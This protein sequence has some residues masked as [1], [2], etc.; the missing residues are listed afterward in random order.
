MFTHFTIL[1]NNEHEILQSHMSDLNPR[2]AG[3]FRNLILTYT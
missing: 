3:L 1:I 2:K